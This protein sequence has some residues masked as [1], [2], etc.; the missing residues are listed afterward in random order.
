MESHPDS[1]ISHPFAFWD[2][3][4]SHFLPPLPFF[5]FFA[6]P[7]RGRLV[8]VYFCSRHFAKD[9]QD[10]LSLFQIVAGSLQVKRGVV[11]KGLVCYFPSSREGQTSYSEMVVIE[12]VSKDIRCQNKEIG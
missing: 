9:V 11:R 12:H 5:V 7:N 1:Q 6:G 10:F 4:Q 8:P 2:P 3:L